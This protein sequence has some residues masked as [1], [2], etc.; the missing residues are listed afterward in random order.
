MFAPV[1][2]SDDLRDRIDALE[3]EAAALAQFAHATEQLLS[4]LAEDFVVDHR[5][6]GCARA[7]AADV[8]RRLETVAEELARLGMAV[9]R[10]ARAEGGLA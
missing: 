3:I 10:K 2:T 7:L 6:V 4:D 8:A 1:S 5:P 9:T